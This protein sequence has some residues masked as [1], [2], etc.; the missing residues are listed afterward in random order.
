[1]PSFDRRSCRKALEQSKRHNKFYGTAFDG[2]IMSIY[3]LSHV[4][5]GNIKR[6]WADAYNTIH[7]V[8]LQCFQSIMPNPT[9]EFYIKRWASF[10]GIKIDE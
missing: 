10:W 3:C 5:V 7:I 9:F 1:M 2:D 8:L 4:S 6:Y